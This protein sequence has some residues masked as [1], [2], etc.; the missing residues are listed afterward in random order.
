MAASRSLRRVYVGI[1]FN[2]WFSQFFPTRQGAH[3]YRKCNADCKISFG[4]G[5]N[6]T[7]QAMR[8]DVNIRGLILCAAFLKSRQQES[9]NKSERR[10]RSENDLAFSSGSACTL[11][12]EIEEGV[13]NTLLGIVE[14]GGYPGRQ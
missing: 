5:G 6:L 11:P 12:G 4:G 14:I 3:V 1:E 10:L 13:N 7:I 9:R 8:A 2:L